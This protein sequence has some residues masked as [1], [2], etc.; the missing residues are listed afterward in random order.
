MCQIKQEP[1][2]PCEPTSSSTAS[3]PSSPAA[4]TTGAREKKRAAGRTKFMETRHPVFRGVRRRCR[5]VGRCRWVCE[6]RVPGRRGC[7]LW[8]GTFDSPDAAARAHDAAMLAL[9]GASASL[10]FADSAW[11]LDVPPPAALRGEDGGADAGAVRCAVA[12]AVEGFRRV[13][14]APAEDTMSATSGTTPATPAA[15]DDGDD[16]ASSGKSHEA[17]PF[18]MDVMSDMGAGLY[19]ASMA[20]GLLAEPPASEVPCFG[21]SDCDVA[22][23]PLWGY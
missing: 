1:S 18:V 7:R 4:V 20:Q 3:T 17:S 22:V 11:L 12:S 15:A 14:S 23:V 19:Y 6:V 9:C 8:L 16:A 10:N 5:A 2:S 13:H 21:D